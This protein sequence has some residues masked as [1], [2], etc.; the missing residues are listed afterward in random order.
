MSLEHKLRQSWSSPIGQGN[1]DDFLDT[2]I[3]E[4]CKHILQQLD[5]LIDDLENQICLGNGHN[6]QKLFR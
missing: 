3:D 6:C 5:D 4:G 2:D 1:Q